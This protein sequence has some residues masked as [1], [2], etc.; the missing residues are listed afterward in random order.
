M[1]GGRGLAGVDAAHVPGVVVVT[2]APANFTS[3]SW[4]GWTRG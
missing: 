1:Y 3:S 2:V 4:L